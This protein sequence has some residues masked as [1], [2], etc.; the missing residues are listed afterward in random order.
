MIAHVAEAGEGRGRIV[1]QLRSSCPS[2]IA[3]DAALVMAQAFNAEIEGVFVEDAQL[4][5]LVRF[6]FACE[7]GPAGRR[8]LGVAE[9][10]QDLRHVAA[11]VLQKVE[12]AARSAGIPVHCRVM[13]DAPTDALAIA[14]AER[15]PWNLVAL[16]DAFGPTDGASV[17][18]L[19]EA[20]LQAT[21][22]MLVGPKARRTTGPVVIALEDADRLP[23][24]LHAADRLAA[25][26][27]ERLIALIIAEDELHA[28]ILEQQVRLL[29]GDRTDVL[30]T[31]ADIV[32]GAPEV[33]A[34]AIRRIA[35]GFVIAQFGRVVVPNALDLTPL[36]TALE[37]PLL[38]VR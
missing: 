10:E 11:A 27:T 35:P 31:V 29:L 18:A 19:L 15:G 8:M 12:R 2:T 33:A 28:Q 23:G 26:L 34:E 32:R 3:L 6:P 37:C 24:M 25:H 14:C 22:V 4:L 36:A 30:I 7:I 9:L 17:G 21:G 5:D 16:A 38:L 1:L 20:A 13:R